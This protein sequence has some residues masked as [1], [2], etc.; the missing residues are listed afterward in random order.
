MC[1]PT[2]AIM[3]ASTGLQFQMQ[4]AQ[5]Q[6]QYAQQKRQN[7]LAKANAIQRYAAEQLKIRQV[8]QRFSDKEYQASRKARKTRATYITEAGGAGLAISGS[9]ER[10]LGDYYRIEGNYKSSLAKNMNI[11]FSQYERNLDAIQF[12]QE[13]Q[14]TYESPPNPHLLFATQAL[15]VANTYWSLE[16]QKQMKGL[17]TNSEKRRQKKLARRYEGY[18]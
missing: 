11:N 3:V 18:T 6:N 12:G 7:D 14:M 15:N 16:S 17:M 8:A 9:T 1:N 4:K 10:L 2:T 5:A 13:A